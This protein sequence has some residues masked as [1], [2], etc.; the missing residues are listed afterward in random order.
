MQVIFEHIADEISAM[1]GSEIPEMS[2]KMAK[3]ISEQ[4]ANKMA[5]EIVMDL[6]S[7]SETTGDIPAE[8]EVK[9]YDDFSFSYML[10]TQAIRRSSKRRKFNIEN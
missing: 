1:I 8:I 7:L 2:A 3:K 9:I 10:N 5:E 4:V 6:S